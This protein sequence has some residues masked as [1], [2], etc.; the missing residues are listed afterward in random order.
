MTHNDIISKVPAHFDNAL[1]A[2]D[3]LFF[4]STVVKHA[5]SNIEYEIRLCPALQ[6]KP[7]LP[8]PH[9][10]AR[11][12]AGIA[13]H[14]NKGKEFDPFSPP[15][16]ANLYVG[17]LKDEESQEEFV[18]LLNKYSVVPNHF[19]MV[20]KEFKSQASPLMPSELVQAYLLLC[21]A[22]KSGKKFFAFY[23]CGDNSGASQAHKHLQFIPLDTEDGPPIEILTRKA[24]IQFVDRPFSLD[25]LSYANHC[26]RLPP[27]LD[28]YTADRLEVVMAEAFLQLLDLAISTIRH[29]PEY[30]TGSPSYN[31]I[32]TLEHMHVIPRCKEHHILQETGER[33]SVNA[34]GY[35]GMLLVKSDQE[36]EA[37]KRESISKILRGVALASVHD[38]QVEGTS[39]EQPLAGL[40]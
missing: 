31:V 9:F 7:T 22:R 21:A 14:G 10:D 40:L 5:D 6:R 39:Q 2:G 13:L 34:L 16:N 1:K 36:L 20:T 23:N 26:F 28:T 37:V 3:L 15:Y 29:D 32:L 12:D 11:V 38:I 27:L 33:L 18:I 19:L 35:A 17:D 8:A 30:P 25:Q 24:Q 4:P